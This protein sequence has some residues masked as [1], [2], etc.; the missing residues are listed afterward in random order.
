M[1]SRADGTA[2]PSQRRW[3]WLL[4]VVAVGAWFAAQPL[5]RSPEMPAQKAAAPHPAVVVA[6]AG[7]VAAA[8]SAAPGSTPTLPAASGSTSTD[9]AVTATDPFQTLG[10]A[11]PS[12]KEAPLR[13]PVTSLQAAL[14]APASAGAAATSMPAPPTTQPKAP[15]V[16]AKA[17]PAPK[18]APTARKAAEAKTTAKAPARKP[19]DDRTAAARPGGAKDP[20]VELLNAI[21]KHLGDGKTDGRGVSAGGSKAAG[22]AA[23]APRSAQT[24]AE[25]VKSCKTKDSIEALLCQRRICEGSWGKAEAC[26][27]SRAPTATQAA[28]APDTP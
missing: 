7:P 13:N 28:Q 19:A 8:T 11:A 20:D 3:W 2:T 15:P 25:L 10:A 17:T 5:L 9:A 24:I 27:S 26:P 6:A 16:V 14:D 22:D 1:S 4:P 23:L 18:A 12:T 21:M